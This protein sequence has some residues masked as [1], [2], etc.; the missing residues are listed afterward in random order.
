MERRENF[1]K[2]EQIDTLKQELL[3]IRQK[4]RNY[5]ITQSQI[6]S[7]ISEFDLTQ[8]E[9]HEQQTDVHEQQSPNME[10]EFD[11]FELYEL[12]D[13]NENLLEKIIIQKILQET[14]FKV[15]RE[16]LDFE[17]VKEKGLTK[18]LTKK[19]QQIWEEAKIKALEVK[20]DILRYFELQNQISEK[21]Q[22][23]TNIDWDNISVGQLSRFYRREILSAI[24]DSRR[25]TR[26][27][28]N[29]NVNGV[30]LD[31]T[32]ME[33]LWLTPEDV[34]KPSQ[35]IKDLAR[36]YDFFKIVQNSVN[37]WY[38]FSYREFQMIKDVVND[39][40]NWKVVLFTWDTGSW[41]T[42]LARFIA[43]NFISWD[44][45]FISG[46]KDKEESDFTYEK[47]VD[48]RSRVSD[49]GDNI[50]KWRH[51]EAESMDSDQRERAERLWND[52]TKSH[53][54][55]DQAIKRQQEKNRSIKSR[56]CRQ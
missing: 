34:S 28:W 56:R 23:Q 45:V 15:N 26:N 2:I 4:Y 39:L 41:K 31:E 6:Q 29:Y 24:A 13:Y 42:E 22:E 1:T 44:H 19:L 43:D 36:K 54:L 32:D 8:M 33:I 51:E 18:R 16:Q 50:V 21:E 14:T 52:I 40:K 35:E 20:K 38:I 12:V 7:V 10:K 9:N 53:A 48:S 37:K 5:K 25:E 46:S 30:E 17:I 49:M 3:F 47:V 55:K 11:F 27:V